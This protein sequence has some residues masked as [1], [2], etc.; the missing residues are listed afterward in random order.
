MFRK[1]AILVLLFYYVVCPPAVHISINE[2]LYYT[3]FN[4]AVKIIE[5]QILGTKLDDVKYEERGFRAELTNNIISDAIFSNPSFQNTEFGLIIHLTLKV[6]LKSHYK[7]CQN[8]FS[9]CTQYPDC[10]GDMSCD[11]VESSVTIFHLVDNKGKPIVDIQI[12]V[13]KVESIHLNKVCQLIDFVK[14]A[15]SSQVK[16][17]V[18]KKLQQ[19]IPSII[20]TS[21][22][23]N[24][25]KLNLMIKIND[26]LGF[27]WSLTSDASFMNSAMI[28][29]SLGG[30]Y[31][32]QCKKNAPFNS[33]PAP[34]LITSQHLQIYISETILMNAVNIYFTHNLL[35]T[36][37]TAL[38]GYNCAFISNS[39]PY[40]TINEKVQFTSG[41]LFDCLLQNDTRA[42]TIFMNTRFNVTFIIIADSKIVVQISDIDLTNM[43][44]TYNI[45]EDPDIPDED[46]LRYFEKSNKWIFKG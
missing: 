8:I 6:T 17:L 21:I 39:T 41:G 14:N 2:P 27:D 15:F 7:I 31:D 45:F 46:S 19:I 42:F 37:Y 9:K 22:Q 28:L 44:F 36:N 13:I 11:M 40:I 26:Y 20:S 33:T 12:P 3:F 5:P 23:K 24:L 4:Y 29:H 16:D 35:K 1:Y 34:K 25:D 38:L 32:I 43:S 18:D 30:I 10:N